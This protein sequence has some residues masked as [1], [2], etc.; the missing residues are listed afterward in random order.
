[1]WL[2]HALE[3]QTCKRVFKTKIYIL[4]IIAG[5][6]LLGERKLYDATL[7]CHTNSDVQVAKKK[8]AKKKN[9]SI[10]KHY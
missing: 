3:L 4:L 7:F 8:G 9:L 10:T 5:R 2:E 1:M 6:F